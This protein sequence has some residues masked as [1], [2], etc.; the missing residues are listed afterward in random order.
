VGSSEADTLGDAEDTLEVV[1]FTIGLSSEGR[2]SGEGF[3]ADDRE[4][5]A[6]DVSVDRDRGRSPILILIDTA[7][8]ASVCTETAM[9]EDE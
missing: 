5:G 8:E 1:G 9:A 6:G 3:V 2:D 4:A 7:H